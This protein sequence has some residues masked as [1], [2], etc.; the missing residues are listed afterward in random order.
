MH[1]KSWEPLER[2]M[3][4]FWR[5]SIPSYYYQPH[6]LRCK[7]S[8]SG[9]Q[10]FKKNMLAGER[11]GASFEVTRAFGQEQWDQTPQICNSHKSVRWLAV[12]VPCLSRLWLKL[13]GEQGSGPKGV[14]DLCFHTYGEFSPPPWGWNL[15]LE[16]W[17]RVGEGGTDVEEEGEISPYVWKHRSST[18]SGP[19][20]CSL[21]QLQTQPI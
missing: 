20:P 9:I 13:R 14:D 4:M 7:D 5:W 19:L 1:L 11:A 21:P 10:M 17:I 6:Y 18:P 3:N 12:P 2:Y 8:P 16:A 15:G